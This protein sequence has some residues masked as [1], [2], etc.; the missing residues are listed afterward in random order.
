MECRKF[1]CKFFASNHP[2]LVFL[3]HTSTVKRKN[4]RIKNLASCF[5][6]DLIQG[7]LISKF[8]DEFQNQYSAFG[9]NGYP[10]IILKLSITHENPSSQILTALLMSMSVNLTKR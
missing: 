2:P 4:K 5:S 10:G 8:S 6:L 3:R 9:Y 1:Q 7:A